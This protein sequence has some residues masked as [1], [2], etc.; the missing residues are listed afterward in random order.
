VNRV[1]LR[2]QLTCQRYIGRGTA[3]FAGQKLKYL[4][5]G[6]SDAEAVL[7]AR[8]QIDKIPQRCVVSVAEDVSSTIDV[9]AVGK[10]LV[11]AV[12]APGSDVDAVALRDALI[13]LLETWVDRVRPNPQPPKPNFIIIL[14]DDQRADTSTATWMPKLAETIVASGVSLPNGISS[15]PVCCP[16]RSTILSGQYAHT[17]GVFTNNAGDLLDPSGSI[18]AFSDVSTLATWLQSA[19]YRTGMFGKYLNGY[20]QFS[21][22][23]AAA[24]GGVHYVPP[25]WDRWYAVYGGKFWGLRYIDETG[26]EI[27]TDPGTCNG[28]PPGEPCPTSQPPECPYHT[29]QLRD[30]ALAFIDESV[31]M[32]EPFFL[33]WSTKAP[34]GPACPA[35]RHQGMFSGIAPH[36]PPNYNEGAAGWDPDDDKPAWVQQ[37]GPIDAADLDDFRIRQLESL[38]AVDDAVEAFMNKLQ[39]LDLD[40][41]TLVVFY[42]DNGYLWGEH[43]RSQ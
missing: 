7:K 27:D 39:E 40:D 19:G 23:Y 10:Q 16:S 11:A 33:Y 26:A 25:G 1:L 38:Q 13:T 32:G 30:Q 34:H 17:H 15:N 43:R 21:D 5:Q 3:T 18:R 35:L 12:G 29:D 20:K 6:L 37:Q 2:D 41:R 36:R 8:K 31:Q 28:E 14:T 24:H 22:E 4:I 42:G 9:P